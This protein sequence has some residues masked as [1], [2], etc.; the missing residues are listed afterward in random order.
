MEKPIAR[1]NERLTFQKN[2]VVTDKNGNHV[3]VWADY[4][5]CF[6]YAGTYQYDRE[7][8]EAVT[9]REQTI[10]FEVRYCRELKE[11]DS[12]HYRVSFHGNAYDIESVDMMNYQK[13]TV[14]IVCRLAGKEAAR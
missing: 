10:R 9:S 8:E 4:Y 14:K 3:N 1:F 5:S 11:L 12:T 6:C 2:S 13:R 7:T